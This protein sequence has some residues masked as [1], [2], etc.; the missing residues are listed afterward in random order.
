MKAIERETKELTLF[1][2]GYIEL[3]NSSCGAPILILWYSVPTV[4]YQ[5]WSLGFSG[6][7][8]TLK[9]QVRRLVEVD[10]SVIHG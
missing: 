2:E 1:A 9:S 7:A 4:S 5:T 3:S 10:Y 8:E 6:F